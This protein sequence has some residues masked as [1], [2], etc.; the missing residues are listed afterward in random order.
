MA[1]KDVLDCLI[2]RERKVGKSRG[3]EE[4]VTVNA[5]A[6]FSHPTVQ[7]KSS[8]Y[9]QVYIAKLKFASCDVAL[10]PSH[11]NTEG[12]PNVH[13]KTCHGW[14]LDPFLY[15]QNFIYC[16]VSTQRNAFQKMHEHVKNVQATATVG[17]LINNVFVHGGPKWVLLEVTFLLM[18]N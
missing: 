1:T 9:S 10:S 5:I 12:I 18:H 6:E 15:T 17:Q 14:T 8:I 11:L 4:E 2:I 16:K 7:L 13:S 3:G